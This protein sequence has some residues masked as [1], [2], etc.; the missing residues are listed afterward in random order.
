[1]QVHLI[2]ALQIKMSSLA[3]SQP[4]EGCPPSEFPSLQPWSYLDYVLSANTAFASTSDVP[5]STLSISLQQALIVLS[6]VDNFINLKTAQT[7]QIAL[8]PKPVPNLV[9]TI[10]V[11]H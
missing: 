2:S 9:K 11:P 10:D 7:L 6:A 4:L 3:S 8:R 5:K 1:M